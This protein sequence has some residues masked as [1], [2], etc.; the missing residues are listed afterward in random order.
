[1]R[2]KTPARFHFHLTQYKLPFVVKW[3]IALEN[4]PVKTRQYGDKKA[5]ELV[6]K[7]FGELHGVLPDDEC[8]VTSS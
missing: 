8:V 3:Q 7:S 2:N 1:M 4:D 6:E 5:A